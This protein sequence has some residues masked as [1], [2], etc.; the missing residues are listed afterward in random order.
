M[1]SELTAVEKA[2]MNGQPIEDSFA[3]VGYAK[4]AEY[5][6]NEQIKYEPVVLMLCD[7]RHDLALHPL[8]LLY[9]LCWD[10]ICCD[11]RL[12]QS[13]KMFT[14]L[15]GLLFCSIEYNMSYVYHA[16]SAYFDRDNVALPGMASY[17]RAASE[18]ERSH[19]QTLMD[20]QVSCLCHWAMWAKLSRCYNN[21]ATMQLLHSV[22]LAS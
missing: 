22:S 15:T 4:D 20:F 10:R 14:V 12:C 11:S 5:A 9:L 6:V 16:M 1:K 17:F 13:S 2:D 19:A 21:A 18:E 7:Y 8:L 3:R